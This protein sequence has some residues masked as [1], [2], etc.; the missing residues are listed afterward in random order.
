MSKKQP[1]KSLR[2]PDAIAS[3]PKTVERMLSYIP[4]EDTEIPLKRRRRYRSPTPHN[5]TH[6][7]QGGL[8]GLGKGH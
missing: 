5:E 1:K 6:P 2:N 8:P 3:D 4:V 7:Y